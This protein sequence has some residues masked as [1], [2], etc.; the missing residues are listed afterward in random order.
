MVKLARNG[1][2][3]YLNCFRVGTLKTTIQL[4][5]SLAFLTLPHVFNILNGFSKHWEESMIKN[6]S[7][8]MWACLYVVKDM[9]I[10]WDS[11]QGIETFDL[12]DCH[13]AMGSFPGSFAFVMLTSIL[14]NNSIT[15]STYWKNDKIPKRHC[16][17]NSKWSMAI[18]WEIWTSSL[19][20]EH[21]E[22]S[23]ANEKIIGQI[24]ILESIS[25]R[26]ICSMGT[27]MVEKAQQKVYLNLQLH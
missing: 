27:I 12:K 9:S 6:R 18:Y 26:S 15:R 23:M 11:K 5:L 10:S 3:K 16:F 13:R 24:E 14:S 25:R 7:C 17:V 8:H 1:R 19:S 21:I 4:Q 22:W 2:L 20:W